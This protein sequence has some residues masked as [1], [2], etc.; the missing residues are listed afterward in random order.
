MTRLSLGDLRLQV[1]PGL[2]L[3]SIGQQVH[4]DGSLADGLV[5]LEQVLAGDPAILDGVLPGLAVLSHADDDVQA[6]VTEV[7]ALA[8]A[9]GAIADQGE[10]VVLEVVLGLLSVKA[11][12]QSSIEVAARFEWEGEREIGGWVTHQEL[13]LGPVITL[14]R[15]RS[16][17][18]KGHQCIN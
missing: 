2:G 1:G 8:V 5:D 13:L 15:G 16:R 17:V 3:G 6:V 12:A 7:E 11:V 10:G 9:L 14:W 18:R 4:D